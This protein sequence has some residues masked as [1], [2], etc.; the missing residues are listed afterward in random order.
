[1]EKII[2]VFF[3]VL[4]IILLLLLGVWM[5]RKSFV[6]A[7]VIG[8]IKKITL[9]IAIPA[10]LFLTFFRADV[11]RELLILA[12]VTFAACMA[13]F[14]LGFLVKRQRRSANPYL[15][16]LFTTFLTGPVGFPL[17]SAYFGEENLYKLAILDAGHSIFLFTVLIAYMGAVGKTGGGARGK[18]AGALMVGMMKSPMTIGMLAGI[19]LSL[20]GFAPAIQGHPAGAAALETVDLAASGA[21]SLSLLLVGYELPTGIKGFGRTLADVLVRIGLMLLIAL[22]LNKLVI[23][24]WLGM[25]KSYQAALYTMFVLPPSFIIPLSITGESREKEYVMG[26]IALHLLVSLAVFIVLMAVI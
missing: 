6:S 1:M 19:A 5:R 25:D 4:P 20:S 14:G 13:A 17:F 16:A 8:G 7:Q 15:P 12:A 21:F 26:F 22:A 24:G 23:A 2:L 11:T 18:S 10:I 3:R 9:N